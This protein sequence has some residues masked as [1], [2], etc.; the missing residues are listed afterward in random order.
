MYVVPRPS[1]EEN[2]IIRKDMREESLIKWCTIIHDTG[3]LD[4]SHWIQTDA[5]LKTQNKNAVSAMIKC[6]F[7]CDHVFNTISHGLRHF[8]GILCSMLVPCKLAAWQSLSNRLFFVLP[9]LMEERS[10][11]SRFS[12]DIVQKRGL[13]RLSPAARYLWQLCNEQRCGFKTL[14]LLLTDSR[15]WLRSSTVRPAGTCFSSIKTRADVWSGSS[16]V[17]PLLCQT[18]SLF[19]GGGLTTRLYYTNAFFYCCYTHHLTRTLPLCLIFMCHFP[20][21]M[22]ADLIKLIFNMIKDQ[23]PTKRTNSCRG[24]FE[25]H[26]RES[27]ACFPFSGD[28]ADGRVLK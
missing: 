3:R 18:D 25:L 7:A 21:Q 19:W 24:C 28:A 2:M 5:G 6:L 8:F 4:V 27:Q 23:N 15:A 20:Q 10:A 13:K 9:H 26:A 11:Q 22:C 12:E 17:R 16:A 1:E 14:E